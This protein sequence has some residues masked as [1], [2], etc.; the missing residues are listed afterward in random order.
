MNNRAK[1]IIKWL[2]TFYGKD[3]VQDEKYIHSDPVMLVLWI[4]DEE[5]ERFNKLVYDKEYNYLSIYK[6]IIDDIKRYFQVD[7]N[8]SIEIIKNWYSNKFNVRVDESGR[9]S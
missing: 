6:D 8:E 3:I 9:W 4:D 2:N 7:E 1:G 5:G